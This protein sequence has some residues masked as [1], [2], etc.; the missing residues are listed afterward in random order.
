LEVNV[1]QYHLIVNLDKRQYL[2]PHAFGEGAKLLEF[3]NASQGMLTALSV[4]LARDNGKGGGDLYPPEDAS[5]VELIGSW[6]G[7]RILIAGDYGEPGDLTDSSDVGLF[8]L[9]PEGVKFAV[10]NPGKAP[11]LYQV[12][13]SVFDNVSDRVIRLL[14]LSEGEHTKLRF[15][16][17]TETRRSRFEMI[18]EGEG[19]E[20]EHLRALQYEAMRESVLETF[21]RM[22]VEHV[23]QLMQER[24]NRR[25]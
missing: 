13:Q 8:G 15:V 10:R 11:N 18:F 4:L 14:Q 17:L 19:Q 21:S 22:P 2:E 1:G 20:E 6:A 3:G 24:A 9:T 16:D 25:A 23:A 12:V 7:D 5:D